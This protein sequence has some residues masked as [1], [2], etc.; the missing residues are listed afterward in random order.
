MT[1]SKK[2]LMKSRT[3]PVGVIYIVNCNPTI[4][5]VIEQQILSA[6][7][8]LFQEWKNDWDLCVNKRVKQAKINVVT[9][10]KP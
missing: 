2:T 5:L 3:R 9:K 4:K 1:H 6:I 8:V 7:Q 10:Y